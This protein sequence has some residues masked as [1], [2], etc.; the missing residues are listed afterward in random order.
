[1]QFIETM[2]DLKTNAFFFFFLRLFG[3]GSLGNMK[4]KS[5]HLALGK[6]TTYLSLYS[7]FTLMLTDPKHS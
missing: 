4:I 1:M 2:T 6:Q 7:L 3:V 5:I